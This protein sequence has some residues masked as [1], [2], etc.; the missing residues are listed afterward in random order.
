MISAP[1]GLR[2]QGNLYVDGT[3]NS[4]DTSVLN[5]QDKQIY[6]S[7]NESLFEGFLTR[8]TNGI[9]LNLKGTE[10]SETIGNTA[11]MFVLKGIRYLI[12]LEDASLT[13][14]DTVEIKEGTTTIASSISTPGTTGSQISFQ[15]PLS[16]TAT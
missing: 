12:K 11:T 4:V 13:A 15:L 6:L 14:A 9:V 1:E 8:D 10:Y 2:V 3:L 7:V 16:S 5:A